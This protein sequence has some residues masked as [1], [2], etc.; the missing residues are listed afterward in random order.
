MSRAVHPCGDHAVVLGATGA[1]LA[2]P[3]IP[4][5]PT[6]KSRLSSRYVARL[7]AAASTD[8]ALARAF[9]RVSG[10]LDPPAALLRPDRV[11]RVLRP[12]AGRPVLTR[13]KIGTREPSEDDNAGQLRAVVAWAGRQPR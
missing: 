1:D 2:H 3:A 7:H 8:L 11:L 6:V 4:G 13:N 12:G 9:V 5:H 10:L